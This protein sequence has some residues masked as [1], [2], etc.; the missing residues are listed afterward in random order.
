MALEANIPSRPK[1]QQVP[2]ASSAGRGPWCVRGPKGWAEA[3]P[4]DVLPEP[5]LP[6]QEAARNS[7]D[8]PESQPRQEH[9]VGICCN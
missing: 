4:E 6:F 5:Y 3:G 1:T 2:K 8:G 7:E 9:Q